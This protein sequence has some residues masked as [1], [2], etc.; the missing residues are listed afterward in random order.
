MPLSPSRLVANMVMVITLTIFM[1]LYLTKTQK[2]F[3][4]PP[5]ACTAY[6]IKVKNPFSVLRIISLIFM[7][8]VFI[9][10]L[11]NSFV[12]GSGVVVVVHVLEVD[13]VGLVFRTL[14]EMTIFKV[15]KHRFHF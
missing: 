8:I 5:E 2:S 14:E 1:S 6:S 12:P 11:V 9:G 13:L 7:V 15:S 4:N 3:A 10:G